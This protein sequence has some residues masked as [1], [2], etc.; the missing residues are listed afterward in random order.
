MGKD[1]NGGKIAMGQVIHS[2]RYS[3][4]EKLYFKYLKSYEYAIMNK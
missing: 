2:V 3:T 1:S 4:Q